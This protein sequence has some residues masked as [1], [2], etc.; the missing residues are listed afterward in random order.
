MSGRVRGD[1]T[2]AV[3]RR[4][5][6]AGGEWGR[7]EKRCRAHMKPIWKRLQGRDRSIVTP[8]VLYERAEQD[9]S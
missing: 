7:G 3:R 9:G 4:T 2:G 6:P 1:V 8:A 5:D